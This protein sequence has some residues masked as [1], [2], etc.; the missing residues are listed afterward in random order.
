MICGL[1]SSDLIPGNWPLIIEKASKS[2]LGILA[3]MVLLLGALGF[4][5]FKTAAVKVRVVIYLS[6][7]SGVIAYGVA[8]SRAAGNVSQNS[9]YRIRV[10]VIG[11][12]QTPVDDAHVSST[13]G[14]ELMR[15]EGGWM[16]VIASDTK[17][18]DGKVTFYASKDAAY[19]KGETPY[20]LGE[21][22]NPT[23]TVTLSTRSASV[24]GMVVDERQRAVE[25]VTIN[26]I[27]YDIEAEITKSTGGFVLPAHAA[28]GQQVQ[29]HAEKSGYGPANSWCPAGD[30][31][32]TILLRRE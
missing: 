18:A 24:R 23:V 5:F 21:D 27:G 8:I 10:V 26:V 22:H 25:G 20:Q 17:P 11:P 2:S 28:D 15:V 7:L 19:Q 14:G 13:G 32:C 12:H 1:L 30:S 31:P 3:L 16:F 4:G 6:L 9:S 29:L